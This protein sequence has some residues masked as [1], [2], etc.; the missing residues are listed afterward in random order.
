MCFSVEV[1]E[2]IE[3]GTASPCSIKSTLLNGSTA[4]EFSRRDDLIILSV[5]AQWQPFEREQWLH[6]SQEVLSVIEG[7]QF[8]CL[9]LPFA[10]EHSSTIPRFA[11]S[12][13]LQLA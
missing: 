4:H 6:T 9:R 7:T 2:C 10:P 13:L 3:E 5:V 1:S 12:H 8:L 11:C